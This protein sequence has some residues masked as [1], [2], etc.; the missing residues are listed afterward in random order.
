MRRLSF[1]GLS[2][3]LQRWGRGWY[4]MLSS[5]LS[6]VSCF[7]ALGALRLFLEQLLGWGG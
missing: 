4:W 2:R 6:V 1:C 5:S 3:R 7:T